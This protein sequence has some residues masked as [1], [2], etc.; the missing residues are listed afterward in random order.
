M[1]ARPAR[2]REP[3]RASL[4][5]RSVRIS[6]ADGKS[7]FQGATADTAQ[8]GPC[9]RCRRRARYAEPGRPRL[10]EPLELGNM[11]DRATPD[12]ARPGA[13]PRRPRGLGSGPRSFTPRGDARPSQEAG[14]PRQQ[15]AR[16]RAA[17]HPQPLGDVLPARPPDARSDRELDAGAAAPAARC[18]RREP[19]PSDSS[20][21]RPTPDPSGPFSPRMYRSDSS[22]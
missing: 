11:V 10:Q 4:H 13:R 18:T 15:R 8:A 9:L 19:T 7:A 5:G 12:R 17:A 14:L 2:D 6:A 1:D 3:A 20:A 22:R 16:R 21:L